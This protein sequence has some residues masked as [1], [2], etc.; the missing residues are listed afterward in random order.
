[1]R[2]EECEEFS[3]EVERGTDI[4]FEI[5]AMQKYSANYSCL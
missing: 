5:T 2:K 3:L 1:M 4:S